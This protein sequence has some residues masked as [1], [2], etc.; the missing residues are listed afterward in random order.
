MSPCPESAAPQSKAC[1][2]KFSFAWVSASFLH[3]SHQSQAPVVT[4]GPSRLS[5]LQRRDT[6]AQESMFM[7]AC[8]CPAESVDQAWQAC[9]YMQPLTL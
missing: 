7:P 3:E 4:L 9:V 8:S 2:S 6:Q 5:Q 1:I